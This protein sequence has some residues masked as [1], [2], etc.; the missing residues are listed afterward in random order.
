MSERGQHGRPRDPEID[1][2]ILRAAVEL[3]L[4]RGMDGASIEQIARR[5]GVTRVTVYRRWAGKEELILHALENARNSLGD[6]PLYS[7]VVDL[8]F[9]DL[10]DRLLDMWAEALVAPELKRMFSRIAGTAADHPDL[11]AGYWDRYA[12]PRRAIGEA[13]HRKAI[14]EGALAAGTDLNTIMDLLFGAIVLHLLTTTGPRTA[15]HERAYLAG[16]FRHAGF[17]LS[18]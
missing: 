17:R 10:L 16:L 15:A 5:A 6:E 7:A 14:A 9:T 11:L 13:L 12:K 18:S 2:A 1:E 8:P 3:F 4:E